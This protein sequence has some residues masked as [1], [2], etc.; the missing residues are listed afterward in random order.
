MGAQQ[1]TQFLLP[2]GVRKV[3]S[4]FKDGGFSRQKVERIS[5]LGQKAVGLQ[6]QGMKIDG[7]H[8][9]LQELSYRQAVETA[10]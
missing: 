9:D 6:S 2:K 3:V 1:R 4:S 8:G 5:L 10:N 7:P